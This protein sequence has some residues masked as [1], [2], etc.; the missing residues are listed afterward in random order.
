MPLRRLAVLATVLLCVWVRAAEPPSARLV[1]L[2]TRAAVG[3]AAGTPISGFV[4][5]GS[6]AKPVVVRAVGPALAGF[7]VAG[8]LADPRLAVLAGQTTVAE[9]DNWLPGDAAAMGAV[10]AFALPAGSRDAAVVRPLAPGGYTAPVTAPA[11]AAPAAA[12]PVAAPAAAKPQST[13]APAAS[14]PAKPAA[15]AP[16]K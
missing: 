1:N 6:G 7:G 8:S 10:G 2:A 3:G 16:A 4:V 9:N 5:A 14:T 13:P 11:T 15:P 12:A